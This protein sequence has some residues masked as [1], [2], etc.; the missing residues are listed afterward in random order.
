MKISLSILVLLPAVVFGQQPNL[1]RAQISIPGVKGV[2]QLDVGPTTWEAQVRP[3]GKET[4]MRVMDRPDHVLITALLQKVTFPASAEKCRD[5]WW[6]G[7]EKM[8]RD[9]R[10]SLS[11]LKKTSTGGMATVEYVIPELQGKKLQMKEIHVYLGSRDLCAEIHISKVM[12][13]P[14][15]QKLFEEVLSTVRL[16]ADQSATESSAPDAGRK[17]EEYLAHASRLFQE[18]NYAGAAEV[19]QKALDLEKKDRTLS[20]SFFRV[21]VDNLG[22]SYGISGDLSKAKETFE[23]GITQ[24]PEY[25][26]FYYNMA[27]TYGEMGRMDQALGQ[28]RLAYKYKDNMIPGEQFPDPIKDDSFRKFVKD[29]KFVEAVKEMQEP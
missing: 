9:R 18:R 8:M 22:M 15:E 12:F 24:D 28:L 25:P 3:D 19:Y 1:S 27:C 20:K 7:T 10:V 23:Y 29:K 4:Q 26:L 13:R 11:G 6:P 21:L 2:L 17:K 14:E 16:S 5:E